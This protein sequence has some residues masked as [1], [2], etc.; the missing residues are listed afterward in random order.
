LNTTHYSRSPPKTE[1]QT[2]AENPILKDGIK[3]AVSKIATLAA[4]LM[5]N[6]THQQPM[7][8]R[9]SIVIVSIITFV[10]VIISFFGCLDFCFL[11]LKK[12]Q[13]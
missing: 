4:M 9:F 11:P 8:V 10:V 6:C 1:D 12:K 13:F 3:V 5:E 7:S 2:R